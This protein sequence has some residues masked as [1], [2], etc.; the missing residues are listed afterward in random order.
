MKKQLYALLFVMCASVVCAQSQ[1]QAGKGVSNDHA[2]GR[3]AH[4]VTFVARDSLNGYGYRQYSMPAGLTVLPWSLPNFE[5]SVYGIRLNLGW[6]RYAETYGLDAGIFSNSGEFGGIAANLIGNAVSGTCS[7]LQAG[8]VNVGREGVCGLQV[9][10]VNFA[11]RLYG[12]QIGFLNFNRSG[13]VLPLINV[14]L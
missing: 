1:W 9:G 7:G 3:N 5:S 11:G 2:D 12:V 6:G 13:V 14:G 8:L 10:A 4:D